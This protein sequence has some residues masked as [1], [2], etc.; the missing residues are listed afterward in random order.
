VDNVAFVNPDGSKV[1]VAT[2][3]SDTTRRFVV[4]WHGGA[5]RYSLTS[6]ASVTFTWR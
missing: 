6:R 5:F 1:L 2:N 4:S 3:T